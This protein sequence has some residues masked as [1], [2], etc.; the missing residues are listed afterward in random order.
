MSVVRKKSTAE[1]FGLPDP[2]KTGRER[3]LAAAVDLF[4]RNGFGA[5]GIDQVIAAAGVAKTTFYKHF[6]GKDDLMLA[7]VR[8]R[9]EWESQAWGRAVQKLAGDDPIKQLLAILDVM[10]LWFN[11]PDFRGCM[12]LNTAIE[13]PN[14]NDPVHQAAAAHKRKTRDQW[15]ELAK[16]A[17]TQATAAE[18]FADCYAALIE[19]AMILR[20]THDRN[21]AA[22]VVRPAVE[23]LIRTYLPNVPETAGA[24]KRG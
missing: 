2:P 22:R 1:L 4:Y 19:G 7:A 9:D 6:E 3:L 11:D 15:R 17:G 12:F 23:Q 18:T 13:F 16:A 20:Q 5:V 10:D 24:A 14:P 8:R 21:D